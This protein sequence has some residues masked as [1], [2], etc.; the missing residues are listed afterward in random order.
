[1]ENFLALFRA[2]GAVSAG[3]LQ[4]EAWEAVLAD[5]HQDGLFGYADESEESLS[6]SG[7]ESVFDCTTANCF[8]A[9]VIRWKNDWDGLMHALYSPPMSDLEA[10]EGNVRGSAPVSGS[11]ISLQAAFITLLSFVA[12][13]A[14]LGVAGII[15]KRE[16]VRCAALLGL[17]VSGPV[18]FGQAAL[19]T[20]VF[21]AGSDICGGGPATLSSIA[22]DDTHLGY[23]E[24]LMWATDQELTDA[25]SRIYDV[26]HENIHSFTLPNRRPDPRSIFGLPLGDEPIVLEVVVDNGASTRGVELSSPAL[27]LHTLLNGCN[28]PKAQEG[29][30]VPPIVGVDELSEA[31]QKMARRRGPAP[32][33]TPLYIALTLLY[34]SREPGG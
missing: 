4:L 5:L 24:K 10:R 11:G 30:V 2:E 27:M 21:L 22:F 23:N 12:S 26:R 18:C 15:I 9:A 14:L 20:P 6:G 19:L 25:V 31:L 8:A 7:P 28:P 1:M 34:L 13:S 32:V 33:Y 29:Y 16:S 3:R 17:T